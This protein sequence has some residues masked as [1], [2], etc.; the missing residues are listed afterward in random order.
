[1][2]DDDM[3]M[4]YDEDDMQEDEEGEEEGEGF[5]IENEYYNSKG[6]VEDDVKEAVKGFEKVVSM[7][8]EKGEWGFKALKK[9]VKLYFGQGNPKKVVEKFKQ[10]MEYSK[11]AVTSNYSEKALNSILDLVSTGKENMQL[12]DEMFQIAVD[13][14]RKQNNERVWFRTQLK[15]GKLLYDNDQFAKLAK[16]L[17]ELHKSCQNEKGE[18]DQK[19]GSQ[20][21]DIYALEIQ[22]YTA[23]KN[24]KKL[25]ELYLKALNIQSA[26]PHP[27]IMG[28]IRECG[29]KM[30]MREKDW[31]KAYNDF[32]EAFKNYDEAGSPRRI[33]CLKYLVLTSML[34]LSA[35]NP[36][37]AT[38]VKPYK[39]DTEIVAMASLVSAYE[40]HDIKAFEKILASNKSAILD[41][42]FMKDYVDDLLKNIRTQVMLK[43]LTPYTN[44]RIPFIAQELNI[45]TKEVE[46]LMIAL[47]LDNK[48]RGRIDQVNGLLELDSNKSSTYY[49]YSS[50]SRWAT[51]LQQLQSTL[52]NRVA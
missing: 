16:V 47:I 4:M 2:S 19:K 42:P 24:N 36:F 40:K 50:V 44:I 20:L 8:G 52:Q 28:V 39:N 35:I 5:E 37:E 22:M 49:K 1:M 9:L 12:A 25:K 33:Q 11:S 21:V 45:S 7:E 38:E 13:E 15:Q 26:I 34:M 3:D 43:L 10:L 14:L 32:F 18:D 23:T 29:G 46:D 27:R 31:E 30:H 48:I 17:Q 41:D 6:L 51:Q